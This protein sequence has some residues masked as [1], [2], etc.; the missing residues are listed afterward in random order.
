MDSVK[1]QLPTQVVNE[2]E[3][4]YEGVRDVD[5]ILIAIEGVNVA[6]SIVTLATL[7][8]KSRTLAASLR[9]WRLRQPTRSMTLVVKGPTIDLRIDLPPNVSTA[10]LLEQLKPL[11]DDNSQ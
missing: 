7:R 5:G 8:S 4:P 6:A 10:D 2:L 1:L 9:R 3:L 11:L